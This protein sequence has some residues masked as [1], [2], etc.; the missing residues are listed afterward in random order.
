MESS[1]FLDSCLFIVPVKRW[2]QNLRHYHIFKVLQDF[3]EQLCLLFKEFCT[4]GY[5]YFVK[6]WAA[7]LWKG[8][9]CQWC[10]TRGNVGASNGRDTNLHWRY[11]LSDCPHVFYTS[12]ALVDWVWRQFLCTTASLPFFAFSH[13]WL[14]SCSPSLSLG[15]IYSLG[16]TACY[17]E[18][19][20]CN[21]I[22]L[23]GFQ[24]KKCFTLSVVNMI[25]Q[26]L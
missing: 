4:V 3:K 21:V 6:W 5:P 11:F 17:L 26:L 2:S 1:P 10:T 9:Q 8:K 12:E 18:M 7:F 14:L 23:V 16:L 20:K 22:I 13:P 25:E 24:E 15:L 19:I